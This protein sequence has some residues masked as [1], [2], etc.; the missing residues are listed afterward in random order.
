MRAGKVI[1]MSRATKSTSLFSRALSLFQSKPA[2]LGKRSPRRSSTG[3]VSKK[4]KPADGAARYRAA[5]IESGDCA[6]DAVKAIQGIRFLV[7]EV[8]RLPVPDCDKPNCQ[9]SYIRYN[10]RRIWTEDRRAFYSL[11]SSHYIQGESKDRRKS[12]FRRAADASAGAA[13]GSLD[14]FESWFQ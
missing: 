3:V 5:E 2:G 4:R 6:C 1:A 14:D 11:H 9:C 10:D 13:S 8:P 7:R 12:E